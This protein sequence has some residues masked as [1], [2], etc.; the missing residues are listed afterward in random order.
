MP[1]DNWIYVGHMLDM[2]L[3]AKE[4]LSGK[5]RVN[6]DQD[7]VLRLALT[8]LVQVIGEAAQHVSKEFQDLYPQVPWREI[9]GMRHRIVHDYLNVD[10]DVVWEVVQNDLPRLVTILESIIPPEYR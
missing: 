2:S 8:H 6:Y 9:I 7:V 5:D 3:Q 1:K 10:E 4:I